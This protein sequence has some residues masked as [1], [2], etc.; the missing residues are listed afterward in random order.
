MSLDHADP[1]YAG[2]MHHLELN[3]PDPDKTFEFWNWLLGSLGYELKSEFDEG[4][5]WTIGPTYIVVK[6]ADPGP[7]H[8]R[9]TAGLDHVAFHASSRALV[10]NLADGVRAR[11]DAILLYPDSHPFAGDYYALYCES[12]EGITLEVVGPQ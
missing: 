5:S 3:T 9:R 1:D 12:P 2:W 4:Y 6:E 8:E 7:S 10:D 11:D